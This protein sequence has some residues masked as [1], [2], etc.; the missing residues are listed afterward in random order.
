[1]LICLIS[2]SFYDDACTNQAGDDH[3]LHT[4]GFECSAPGELIISGG[5]SGARSA[6]FTDISGLMCRYL[7]ALFPDFISALLFQYCL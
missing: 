3:F 6:M 5:P 4:I 7:R 2:S 1:M